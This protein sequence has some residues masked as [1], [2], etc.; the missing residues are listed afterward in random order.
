MQEALTSIAS[1][2]MLPPLWAS[3]TKKGFQ[4]DRLQVHPYALLFLFVFLHLSPPKII[5]I[6]IWVEG[7][8]LERVFL[9]IWAKYS[10]LYA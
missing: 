9:K 6:F 10:F 1:R 4:F 5:C 2:A 7:R 8:I 3:V